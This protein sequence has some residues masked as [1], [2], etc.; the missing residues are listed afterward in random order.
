MIYTEL[1]WINFLSLCDC[2]SYFSIVE[3]EKKLKFKRSEKKKS[4]KELE[5]ENKTINEGVNK[6]YKLILVRSTVVMVISMRVY[7]IRCRF[8]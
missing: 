4:G 6:M 7:F 1:L 2:Q 3:P 8:E 5:E